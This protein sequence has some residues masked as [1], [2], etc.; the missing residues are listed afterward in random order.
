MTFRVSN[1]RNR[2]MSLL[3]P[4]AMFTFLEEN[5][6]IFLLSHGGADGRED[7]TT[8]VVVSDDGEA[9]VGLL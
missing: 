4:L 7:T 2:F 8:A 5:G 9:G 3:I 1:R 6:D